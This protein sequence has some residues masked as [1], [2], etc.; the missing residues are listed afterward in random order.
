MRTR[1]IR[2]FA[3]PIEDDLSDRIVLSVRTKGFES[4]VEVPVPLKDGDADAFVMSWLKM[5]EQAL[6]MPHARPSP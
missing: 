5:M 1:T 3:P 2:S 4:Q 6:K